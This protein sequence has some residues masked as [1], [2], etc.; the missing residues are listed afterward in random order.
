MV[1]I[2]GKFSRAKGIEL[3]IP[4]MMFH[5]P[6]GL[7]TNVDVYTVLRC[8]EYMLRKCSTNVVK[9]SGYCKQRAFDP[10]FPSLSGD[11]FLEKCDHPQTDNPTNQPTV[12][13]TYLRLLLVPP[14]TGCC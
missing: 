1:N 12:E 2:P 7:A 4:V 11:W 3:H 8:F 10:W 6:V 9:S 5:C 13:P 14:K